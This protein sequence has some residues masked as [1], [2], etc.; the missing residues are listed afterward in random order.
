MLLKFGFVACGA[1]GVDGLFG[2]II[3]AAASDAK[4]APAVPIHVSVGMVY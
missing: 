1:V 4:D 2:E 3:G